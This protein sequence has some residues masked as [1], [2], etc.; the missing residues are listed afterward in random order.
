MKQY[1][2]MA[3]IIDSRKKEQV[4]IMK[5]LKELVAEVNISFSDN[6]LSPLT[7]TLGDEFQGIVSNLEGA[8]N[9]IIFLE[10]EIIRRGVQFK[11]R[12]VLKYGV[13]DTPI[14]S[15]IAY[16]MLGAGLTD[17]RE[18][19]ND[20]KDNK[21]RFNVD[22]GNVLQNNILNKSFKI[23][24]NIIGKWKLDKDYSLISLLIEFK[25][26]K[27]VSEMLHKERS[28][29]WK[30]IKSLNMDDYNSIKDIINYTL[31]IK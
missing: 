27:V 24:D 26:Y 11:L 30:R 3:D 6:V 22:I 28:L 17:A 13:I 23:L 4:V 10:E 2:L 14:N 5:N 29:I 16:E 18:E 1:I 8:I 7:I 20:L 19:L 25:D 31:L 21:N 9:I 15:K 12:Y